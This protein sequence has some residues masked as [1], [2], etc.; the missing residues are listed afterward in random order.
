VRLGFLYPGHAAEDDYPLMAERLQPSPEAHVVHTS[1]GE[2]ANRVDAL[3]DLGGPGRLAEGR[4]V[5][6]DT[7]EGHLVRCRLEPFDGH[8]PRG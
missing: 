3:L 1:V 6:G 8:R 5:R 4:A 7:G 2:D